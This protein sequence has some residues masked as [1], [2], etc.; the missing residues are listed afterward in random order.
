MLP[1]GPYQHVDV[2]HEV[3]E[4]HGQLHDEVCVVHVG[5]PCSPRSRRGSGPRGGWSSWMGVEEI[6][7]SVSSTMQD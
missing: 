7:S 5:P 1:A 2:M 6:P 4:E 3:Q